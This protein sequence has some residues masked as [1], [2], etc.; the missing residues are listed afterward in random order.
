MKMK[1]Q[2][3]ESEKDWQLNTPKIGID[4]SIWPKS[5]TWF[6]KLDNSKW[7]NCQSL[8]QG[9]SSHYGNWMWPIIP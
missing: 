2:K 6:Q 3:I 9:P 7:L 8:F 1:G 5:T 4:L